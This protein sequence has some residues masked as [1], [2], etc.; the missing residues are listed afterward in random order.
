MFFVARGDL[1]ELNSGG[2]R[3]SWL[4]DGAFFGD[5]LFATHA[6]RSTTVRC[7]SHSELLILTKSSLKVKK[8]NQSMN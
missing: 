2:A 1:E 8:N 6:R 7:I 3:T 5:Q 4:T